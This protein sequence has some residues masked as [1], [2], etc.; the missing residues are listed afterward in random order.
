MEVFHHAVSKFVFL[1]QEVCPL[2]KWY[3]I[4][5]KIPVIST[6][7][8]SSVRVIQVGS[9]LE[10]HTLCL[11]ETSVENYLSAISYGFNCTQE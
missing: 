7:L 2:I 10:I 3:F 6:F 1:L 11:P 9:F 8:F 5:S 4:V